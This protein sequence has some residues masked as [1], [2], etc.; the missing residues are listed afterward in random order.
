MQSADPQIRQDFDKIARAPTEQIPEIA[1]PLAARPT[2]VGRCG[3][4][5]VAE[6]VNVAPASAPITGC[7]R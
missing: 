4:P 2:L 3:D 5:W 1:G 6:W 7:D